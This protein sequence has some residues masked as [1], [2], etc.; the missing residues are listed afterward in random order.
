MWMNVMRVFG[1]GQERAAIVTE[2]VCDAFKAFGN[3]L[4]ASIRK[5]T[6]QNIGRNK[7]KFNKNFFFGFLTKFSIKAVSISSRTPSASPLLET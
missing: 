6:L 4:S 1:R 3:T 5:Y 2:L 7:I